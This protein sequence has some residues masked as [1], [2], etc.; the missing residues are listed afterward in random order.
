MENTPKQ[1]QCRSFSSSCVIRTG[2]W[3]YYLE[4]YNKQLLCTSNPWMAEKLMATKFLP[5]LTFSFHS[6]TTQT[7]FV[8]R[9]LLFHII[10]GIF[11]GFIVASFV[12]SIR[13]FFLVRNAL[14]R[15]AVD[16]L[17]VIYSPCFVVAS[18]CV[19]CTSNV[20]ACLLHST[21][22]HQLFV[23]SSYATLCCG[24]FAFST[25]V[26]IPKTSVHMSTRVYACICVHVC[27]LVRKRMSVCMLSGH[28]VVCFALHCFGWFLWV[29]L[30]GGVCCWMPFFLF[31]VGFRII[32]SSK[33]FRWVFPSLW[34]CDWILVHFLLLLFAFGQWSSVRCTYS[35]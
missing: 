12:R 5:A 26:V 22:S 11:V 2:Y 6:L 10:H 29:F 30:R 9:S 19:W 8:I 1:H 21:N 28:V 20:V 18:F 3:T 13:V 25:H 17:L 27:V 33:I 32:L 7:I 35:L 14:Q 4:T 24:S 16:G 31:L 23:Y 34:M 15:Y